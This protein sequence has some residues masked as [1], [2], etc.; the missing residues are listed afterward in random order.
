MVLAPLVG[1]LLGLVV[2]ALLWL[3][4]A[5]VSP[6]VCRGPGGRR[7]RAP[8]PRHAPRRARRHRR[9]PRLAHPGGAA[10]ALMRQSDIGPFGVVTLVLTLFFQTAA[11][12]AAGETSARDSARSSARSCSAGWCCRS[13]ATN[14]CPRRGA[15]GLGSTVAG[16][17]GPV[18]ALS[19]SHWRRPP[20]SAVVALLALL[21]P[22]IVPLAGRRHAT[23]FGD[24]GST[25]SRSSP[26]LLATGLFARHCVRRLGGVTGDVLGACVELTL[27]VA[28]WLRRCIRYTSLPRWHAVPDR[29]PGRGGLTG[30]EDGAD[31][32]RP[33]RARPGDHAADR[34]PDRR[35]ARGARQQARDEPVLVR[36]HPRTWRCGS[37]PVRPSRATPFEADPEPPAEDVL[38]SSAA[39]STTPATS[40]TSRA[41]APG[42]A[43]W[44]TWSPA[45]TTSTS[46]TGWSRPAPP[47]SSSPCCGG[48]PTGST[49]RPPAAASWSRVGRRPT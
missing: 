48:S 35:L 34:L 25:S 44:E 22:G 26:P 39:A 12:V 15:D 46:A 41:K 6:L 43:H 18:G 5:T 36:G 14:G 2:I 13:C 33:A 8:H 40:P 28:W 23:V 7:A 38:A 37:R 1:L 32:R 24:H 4:P 45:P 16:S 9:R 20:C 11:I 47:T 42:R 27:T 3:L 19:L 49:T 10:L 30:S 21:V 17:V 29:V 31:G